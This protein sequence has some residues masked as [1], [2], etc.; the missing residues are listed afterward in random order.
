MIY[1]RLSHLTQ[2][3]AKIKPFRIKQAFFAQYVGLEEIVVMTIVQSSTDSNII[4][5]TGQNSVGKTTAFNI[6]SQEA[7]G[8][9]ISY[10]TQPVSDFLHLLN[11]V[12]K[13]DEAGGFHHYHE[14][15]AE[16]KGGHSH[17]NKEP[18]VPFIVIGN[19][20]IDGMFSDFF[21]FLSELPQSK[22][23]YFAEWTSGIN[24][25]PPYE[26]AS[27]VDC[28]FKKIAQ[29]LQSGFLQRAW[30]NRVKAVIHPIADKDTRY[31]LN[32][33]K[34]SFLLQDL[35]EGNISPKKPRQVLD[36][37]GKDDFSEIEGLFHSKNIPT[38]TIQN[39]ANTLFIENLQEI[40]KE[41]FV[42]AL[43]AAHR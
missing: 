31:D 8:Y 12:R 40:S 34:H 15:T 27:Q 35:E 19:K 17:R 25:N 9:G 24:I 3:R 33:R 7:N 1:E 30:L 38:Y 36:I 43:L 11:N 4:I 28:S 41:L 21:A 37:F 10:E 18:E 13:D 16:K 6:L 2:A 22:N 14:W 23:I 32:E 26:P 42:P 29:S 39:D 5:I 20:V